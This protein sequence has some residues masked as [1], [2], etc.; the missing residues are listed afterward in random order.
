M[1]GEII[2]LFG[3]IFGVGMPL[4]IPIVWIVLNYRK[5]R[6]L[7]ELHHAER[8]AAIERGMDIPPLPMELID[9]SSPRRRRTSLLPGLVWFFIGLAL[10]I[11]MMLMNDDDI[12]LIG[13]LIP[14]GVGAAY[15]IYYFAEGRKIE[16]RLLE[17][18]LEERGNGKPLRQRDNLIA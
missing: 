11:G 14:L 8:M 4:S 7:M 5:R 18:D 6:R 15:L 17:H 9:G 12:P 10:V 13:G 16:S 3:I 2:P 1:V